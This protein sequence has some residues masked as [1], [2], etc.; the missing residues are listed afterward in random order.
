MSVV[1][2]GADFDGNERRGLVAIV[3]HE[4]TSS[5]VSLLDLDLAGADRSVERIVAAYRR[6]LGIV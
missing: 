6:W 3:D 2:T 4:G 5:T 1:V